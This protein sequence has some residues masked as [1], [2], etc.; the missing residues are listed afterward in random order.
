MSRVCGPHFAL[1]GPTVSLQTKKSRFKKTETGCPVLLTTN[2][3]LYWKAKLYRY[4]GWYTAKKEEA[5]YMQTLG[6]QRDVERI[7]ARAEDWDIDSRSQAEG[8]VLGSW[9]ADHGFTRPVVLY[10]GAGI[11]G[12]VLLKLAHW[13]VVLY[14]LLKFD[15]YSAWWK[16]STWHQTK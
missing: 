8:I 15:L 4:T 10:L 13:V 3:T 12:G 1:L 2:Q 14:I 9:Q 6:A 5:E 16:I 11:E 7:F